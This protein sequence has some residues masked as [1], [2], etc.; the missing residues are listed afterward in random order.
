MPPLET[1]RIFFSKGIA[2]S[3]T[4]NIGSIGGFRGKKDFTSSTN[5]VIELAISGAALLV[6]FL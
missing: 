3:E 5:L 4:S 6:D 1:V 2:Q